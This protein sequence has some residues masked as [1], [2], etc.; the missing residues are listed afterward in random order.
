M[1][2][3][4]MPSQDDSD[5]RGRPWE[6]NPLMRLVS[7]CIR[8]SPE[9][10]IFYR[11]GRSS[12]KTK[13]G[14][15]EGFVQDYQNQINRWCT[16][17]HKNVIKMIGFVEAEG[18]NL[19]EEFCTCG[20]V[21]D[22]RWPTDLNMYDLLLID[23]FQDKIYVTDD[24][25]VKLGEFGLAKLTQGFATLAPTISHSGIC[26]WMSPELFDSDN[27]IITTRASD[28]W[29]LGCTL[30]EVIFGQLPYSDC[31]HDIEVVRK[32]KGGVKPGRRSEEQAPSLSYLWPVI[33]A[34]WNSSPEE[35][36]SSYEIL[37]KIVRILLRG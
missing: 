12:Q 25:V 20:T 10:M 7:K 3:W 36:P 6:F 2:G 31:R 17:K 21:R 9:T 13:A 5:P 14:L 35:R 29:A 24:N 33:E 8:I 37:A 18:L 4:P 27:E 30:Y 28:I 32:I 26:R 34:C 16:I 22:R 11:R 19:I 15:W 23:Q 1:F